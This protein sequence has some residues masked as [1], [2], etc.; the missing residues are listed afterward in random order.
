MDSNFPNSSNSNENKTLNS[1][2]CSDISKIN[3]QLESE[4]GNTPLIL[5]L[6]SKDIESFTELLSLGI[7]PN[8]SNY[9][10]DTPLHISVSNNY[11]DFIILLLKNNADCNI[12]NNQGNTPLHLA[13]ENKESNIIQILLKNNIN[14]NIKNNLGLT[15]MHLAIINKVDEG[16][17]K[18]LKNKG[19]D[20]YNIKD[21][22]NKS[23]FDYAKNIGDIFYENLLIKIF[24]KCN[25]N[26]LLD[27]VGHTWK[28]THFSNILNEINNNKILIIV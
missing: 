17:L 28:E 18:C 4:N 11:K 22:F 25:K 27:E 26:N 2:Y 23:G 10:G 20:I 15:P 3:S 12:Q 1:K 8:I 16:I 7:S 9:S 14:P 13:L 19:G 6:L 21:N 5:S 24:G